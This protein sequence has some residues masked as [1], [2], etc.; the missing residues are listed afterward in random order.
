MADLY[1][2]NSL[3]RK[4]EKFVPINPPKVGMYTCGP[5]VYDFATIGNFRTYTAADILYRTLKFDGYEVDYIMNITDVGHLTGDNLGNADT[6]EDRMEK[7]A[8]KQGKSAWD[9]A[10]IYTEAFLSDYEK[11]NLE[12]PKNFVKATD[13]IEDQINLV[14]QLEQKGL[15]YKTS[16]G[17]Y[18]DTQVFEEKTGKKYGELSTLDKIKAGAR[19]KENP[20]KKNPRDFALW[21]FSPKDVKRQMEWDSPWGIGFPGWHIEC[22]AMSMKYLG[23]S[24][25]VHVGGEDLRQTHHPN[26]IAQ[27]EGSTGKL[28][29][30]YWLHAAFLQVDSK[31][32]SKSLGNFYTV[33][34]VEKKGFDPLSLRYL[35]LT[36]HYRDSLNFTWDSLGAAQNTLEN[37]RKQVQGLKQSESRK[38]LSEEKNEKLEGF[39][40]KFIE[41]INDDLNTP[42]AIAI[43]W[44]FLKSN[45]PA[46]DKYDSLM[47]FDE[48][49]GLNLSLVVKKE[50]E[51]PD[52]IIEL[53]NKREK[54]RKD[55]KFDEADEIRKE[56]LARGF[57]VEDAPEGPKVTKT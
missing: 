4:K 11:L 15:T 21:K 2:I 43:M 28:F 49:L 5:T 27:S 20:E 56:I 37:L 44:E 52:E 57:L 1:L 7:A 42:Q 46:Y 10:K 19:V 13:H 53:V 6:G 14:K 45:V 39:R 29:V 24:F 31:R 54:L 48:I 55:G 12:K 22:S 50:T 18:F 30:K 23:E 35:Y 32:M 34:D 40:N 36:A 17:I 3:T 16:D 26:E 8:E 47:T 25:D 41:A 51:I 38:T 9:I 33:S